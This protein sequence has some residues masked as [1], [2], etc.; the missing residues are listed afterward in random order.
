[1]RGR[2]IGREHWNLGSVRGR[3]FVIDIR[4]AAQ[5]GDVCCLP[6]ESSSE[7]CFRALF[8]ATF[9]VSSPTVRIITANVFVIFERFWWH[10]YAA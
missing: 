6:D 2:H 10:F 5:S 3:Q 7:L 4:G 8:L 9:G 1:M